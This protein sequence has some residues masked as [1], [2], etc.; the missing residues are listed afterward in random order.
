MYEH[1]ET[2]TD[3]CEE[4]RGGQCAGTSAFLEHRLDST[5]WPSARLQPR[6]R[7]ISSAGVGCKP[8]LGIAV[9]IDDAVIDT[10]STRCAPAV[11]SS[12]SFLELSSVS[13]AA[14]L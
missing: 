9:F 4:Q 3:A 5:A 8:M 6:R 7:A 1:E 10:R 13:S 2:A 11:P 12:R 14:N